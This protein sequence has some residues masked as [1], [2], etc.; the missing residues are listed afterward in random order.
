MSVMTFGRRSREARNQAIQ[1]SDSRADTTT[2]RFVV[3][4]TL[5]AVATIVV[6]QHLWG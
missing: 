6:G 5:L 3:V 2:I 1:L 4:A